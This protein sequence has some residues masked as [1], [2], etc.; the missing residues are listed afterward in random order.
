VIRGDTCVAIE[1]VVSCQF[2]SFSPDGFNVI[3]A[4]LMIGGIFFARFVMPSGLGILDDET[5]TKV[6]LKIRRTFKMVIHSAILL[7]LI[8]GFTIQLWRGTNTRWIVPCCIRSGAR[9]FCWR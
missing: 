1:S 7:L 9:I 8:T 3:C 6:H 2:S 5:R 4:C